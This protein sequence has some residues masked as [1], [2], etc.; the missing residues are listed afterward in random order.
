MLP[1]VFTSPCNAETM[2][3]LSETVLLLFPSMPCISFARP[4]C[5]MPFLRLSV[6]RFAFA[7]QINAIA[8]L[9]PS[10]LCHCNA[11]PC[12]AMPSLFVAIQ[13]LFGSFHFDATPLL[14]LA[15]RLLRHAK[16]IHTPLHI[17]PAVR[18]SSE[19][20]RFYTAL[21]FAGPLL[22]EALLLPVVASH[23]RRRF[24]RLIVRRLLKT[25]TRRRPPR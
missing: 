23:C 8:V 21:R 24:F 6:R 7:P 17:A 15:P 18:S 5:L 13:R 3:L 10:P 16:P 20:G 25:A 11:E 9:V 22:I 4:G 2:P 12:D 19:L 14:L 1:Q